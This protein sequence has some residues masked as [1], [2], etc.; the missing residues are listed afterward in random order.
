MPISDAMKDAIRAQT[1]RIR[2]TSIAEE[3]IGIRGAMTALITG[4][5]MRRLVSAEY[6]GK[7]R[8]LEPYSMRWRGR[9]RPD[10]PLMYAVDRLSSPGQIKAFAPDRFQGTLDLQESTYRPIW[11]VEF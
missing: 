10:L 7:P 3:L 1:K 11:A 2:G 4:G 9:R 8:L 6:K 5:R